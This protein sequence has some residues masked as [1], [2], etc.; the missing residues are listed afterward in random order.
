MQTIEHWLSQLGL[1]KYLEAFVQNDVDLR[2]LPHVTER[3]L[4]ELGVSLGHRKIIMAAVAGIA[5]PNLAGSLVPSP[6]PAGS[7]LQASDLAQEPTA[8]RRLL[9]VLFCDLVG[10]TAIS[11]QLD[12][13][14][15]HELTRRYQDSVAGAITR[16]GGY[17]AKYLGDGVLAYFGWPMAYEDHAERAIRAGLEALA[18][19]EAFQ[20]P[21]GEQLK[22]RIGIASGH[23]VVGDIAGS[24]ANERASIAGDTPNLAARLQAAAAPG[25][26]VVADAT[27]RLAGQSFEIESL[28]AQE[29]KGFRLPIALFAVHGEREVES[30]F[31]AAQTSALSKFVGRSSEIGMLLDRWELAKNGQGQAVFVSGEAGIGKSRLVDALEERL[32]ENQPELI[33]LQCSPYHSTS[34]FYPIIQR[35]SRLA[36]LSAADE[37]LMRA[38]KLRAIVQRYGEDPSEVGSTYAELLS[39]DLASEFTPPDLSAQQRKELIVR[40]LANRVLLAAKM[41][42]VLFVVEDAHWIDPSTNEFLTEVVRRMHGAAVLVVVTHRPEWTPTWPTGLVHVTTLAIGRLTKQQMREL[43]DSMLADVPDQLADRIVERTDGVPL[44]VEELT[45]SIL[46]SGKA[47]SLNVEIPDSLQ[48]SLMARLDRLTAAAKEVAQ[49]ASVIGREF[50]RGL[51]SKVAGLDDPTLGEALNEL[52]STQLVVVGGVVRDALVFRH[53]LI[54]DTAYQS[55]LSKRRRQYHEAI[56]NALIDAYPDLIVTQPEL[57]AQHYVKAQQGALALPYWMKAGERALGQS[58]NYEAVDHFQNA[59]DI[60]E[61]LPGGPARQKEVL[62]A[63]LKLGEALSAAGRLSDSV[64]KYKLTAHL[65]RETHDTKAFVR[66]ALGFD[67]A[68]FL[69]SKL[70]DES[71]QLLTEAMGMLDPEDQRSRSQLLSRLTRAYFYL[72]DSKNSAKC[73]A[74]G[75]KLARQLGDQASLFELSVLPF[76]TPRTVKSAAEATQLMARVDEIK[77]LA[78][79]IN[80]D[81]LRGRA[82]A[83]DVYVSTELGDRARA[84]QAVEGLEELG[85]LRQR[86]NILWLA[87]NAR[88]MMAILDGRFTTAEKLAGE[89]LGLGRQTHGAEVEGV[90]GMQM[91]TIRREQNR[92]SEVAPVMKNLIDENP[93]ETTWLPGFALVAADLGYR[94]AAQRRLSELARANFAMPPDGKRSASLS[95]V[96]EVAVSLGDTEA[97]RTIYNLMLAYKDMTITA[98]VATVCFGAASRYLGMLS[99]SLGDFGKAAEHFE[100]AMDMNAASE[101]RPWLAHSQAEYANLLMKKGSKK[102]IERAMSLSEQASVTAAELGMVRLQKRLETTVH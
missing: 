71:L 18:A 89:A 94:D 76:L 70:L 81:D 19:V 13:E 28:G 69:S 36:G 44:F 34:A 75:V 33:R 78:A 77:R 16:F 35:L 95:F 20:S 46:E 63:T 68:Q 49:I 7:E 65:A 27:R 98:G 31:D 42:P 10:S 56:A 37:P 8:D 45:R 99:T 11:A 101:S 54:Q 61:H 43:I 57:I 29:L 14:D 73:H 2:A 3:D 51:L 66:S 22:A 53:A 4:Q 39:L 60:A 82:L 25:Q 32:H 74:E 52:M 40:T 9:S 17:V 48:G 26:I 85:T 47:A 21:S 91:F 79:G 64:A 83:L 1:G 92:L 59:V 15:M 58:A 30:R 38:D 72:S 87:W 23:V 86:L 5:Q 41:A 96:A 90:Y 102:A 100:H 55:L 6:S 97:A 88:A 50:D 62:E 84:D 93:D 12:P 67:G 24:S 80:D